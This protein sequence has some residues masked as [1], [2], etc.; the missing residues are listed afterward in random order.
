MVGSRTIVVVHTSYRLIMRIGLVFRFVSIWDVSRAEQWALHSRVIPRPEHTL[1]VQ[2]VWTSQKAR[3]SVGAGFIDIISDGA[4]CILAGVVGPRSL[5][6]EFVRGALRR[7]VQSR[8]SDR[9]FSIKQWNL[10]G[11]CGTGSTS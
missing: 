2:R 5:S 6:Y 7:L 8:P 10:A 3:V 4:S 9:V 11:K 1:H